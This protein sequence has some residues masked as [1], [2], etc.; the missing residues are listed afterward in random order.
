M[1]TQFGIA[2]SPKNLALQ[3]HTANMFLRVLVYIFILFFSMDS[4]IIQGPA[5]IPVDRRLQTSIPK[6][7][8]STA[9][10]RAKSNLIIPY[11]VKSSI[12]PK[13]SAALLR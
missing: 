5:S 13:V 9:L 10:P 4:I 7:P 6:R 3:F 1:K 2:G 12:Y 8:N 11:Q